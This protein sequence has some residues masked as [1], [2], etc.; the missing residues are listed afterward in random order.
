MNRTKQLDG[1]LGNVVKLIYPANPVWSLPQT[2]ANA[3]KQRRLQVVLDE[4][5]KE[6]KMGLGIDHS[7]W[8][9]R[10]G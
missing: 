1:Q 7:L 2:I 3:F 4:F 9:S 5:E 6:K 8:F 10:K